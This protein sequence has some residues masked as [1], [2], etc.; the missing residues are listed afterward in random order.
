MSSGPRVLV[1]GSDG[2]AWRELQQSFADAGEV[3]TSRRDTVDLADH[4]QLRRF[5]RNIAPDIILNAAAYTAV[6]RAESER[7]LAMAVN[8]DAPGDAG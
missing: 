4:E 1:L 2:A 8:A 5:V 6:D 3:V 7:D